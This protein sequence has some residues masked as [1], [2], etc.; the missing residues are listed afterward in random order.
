[1]PDVIR[2]SRYECT[3]SHISFGIADSKGRDIGICIERESIAVVVQP[4]N[5]RGTFYRLSFTPID[6][7]IFSVRGTKTLNGKRFGST[8]RT[9]LFATE[10]EAGAFAAKRIADGRKKAGA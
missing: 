5:D 6:G 1:M 7:K 2:T 3:S 8:Q 9:S 4:D 10:A